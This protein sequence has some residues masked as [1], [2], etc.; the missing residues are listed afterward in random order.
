MKW[1]IFTRMGLCGL[2]LCSMAQ[3]PVSDP[4]ARARRAYNEHQ[5]DAAIAAAREA[6]AL[7]T[8]ANPA[9][10]VLARAHLERFLAAAD[11]SDMSDLDAARKALADVQPAQLSPADRMEFLV[12][13]GVSVYYV[14]GCA[15][16]CLGAAA[17]F[18]ELALASDAPSDRAARETIFEWW[19]GALDRQA[20]FGPDESRLPT[21]KR[22]L[23]GAEAER[24]RD[25][26]ST[27]ATYWIA[28]ASRGVGDFD[29]A[30]GAAV[31][32][33]VRAKYLGPRG[34]TLRADLHRLVYDVLLPERARQMVP[35]A[36]P[37]PHLEALRKQW[38]DVT[39]KYK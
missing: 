18:F 34:E 38:T 13:M 5:Y 23:A 24:A 7:P 12:G 29:R 36:D 14:D 37:R 3:A 8:L 27:S 22:I 33:W 16:G 19:A 31:A 4:L 1:T 20:Q 17:E 2:L 32:G 21:Y 9:A 25:I 26:D 15:D 30:W 6:R 10:V 39:E 28:A 11:K 35:D